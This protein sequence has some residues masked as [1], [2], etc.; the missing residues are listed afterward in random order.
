[1]NKLSATGPASLR[2]YLYINKGGLV[3]EDISASA[4]IDE[5]TISNGAAYADL[6]NDGD[7]DIITNNINDEAFVFINNTNQTNKLP[8]NHFLSISL[9]GDSL[10]T[11]AF[12]SK[13][14]VYNDGKV[15]MQEENPARGYFSSVDQALVFGLGNH[16]HIDSLIVIWPNNTKQVMYGMRVDT[17][18]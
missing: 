11:K 9:K 12:G 13:V 2:N 7:L 5:K 18:I 4:G 10:N 1:M 3:F 14:Y 15:Q 6:D 17:A 16:D 8:A